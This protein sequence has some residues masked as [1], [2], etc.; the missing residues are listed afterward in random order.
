M[1]LSCKYP[2]E[3]VEV[4]DSMIKRLSKVYRIKLN[5]LKFGVIIIPNRMKMDLDFQIKLK[6]DELEITIKKAQFIQEEIELLQKLKKLQSQK[7]RAF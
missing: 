7:I 4:L 2:D 6:E 5:H 3:F 1:G